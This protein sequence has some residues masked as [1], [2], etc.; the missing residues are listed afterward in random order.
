MENLLD[1][2]GQIVTIHNCFCDTIQHT[3]LL[4]YDGGNYL[5]LK[6]EGRTDYI[7]FPI[8]QYCVA[9]PKKP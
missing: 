9:E 6:L 2:N 1:M 8:S 7:R 4:S 3:G 5:W